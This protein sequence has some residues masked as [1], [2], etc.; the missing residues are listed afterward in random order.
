MTQEI[1]RTA[2]A[3]LIAATCMAAEAASAQTGS[4]RYPNGWNAVDFNRDLRGIPE[5]RYEGCAAVERPLIRTHKFNHNQTT[6]Y[7]D[8]LTQK[9][10]ASR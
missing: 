9:G 8:Q 1:Q 10:F 5:G 7:S 6:R 3:I 2:L 4:C